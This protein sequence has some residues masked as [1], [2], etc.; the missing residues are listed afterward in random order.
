M[1]LS[2]TSYTRAAPRLRGAGQLSFSRHE[3]GAV[4][5]KLMAEWILTPLWTQAGIPQGG[6]LVAGFED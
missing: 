3:V 2:F 4:R 5:I 1:N 6:R